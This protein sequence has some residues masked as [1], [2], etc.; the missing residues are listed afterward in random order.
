MKSHLFLDNPL[1]DSSLS[2][3]KSTIKF[4]SNC[5][6]TMGVKKDFFGERIKLNLLSP[7]RYFSIINILFSLTLTPSK[8]ILSNGCNRINMPIL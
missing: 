7:E 2:R 3:G 1:M 8:R 5:I 6:L 4:K